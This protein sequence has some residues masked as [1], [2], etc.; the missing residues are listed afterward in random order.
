MRKFLALAG[1]ALLALMPSV[2]QA[3]PPAPT[4]V[5]GS[6]GDFN[7]LWWNATGTHVGHNIYQALRSDGLAPFSA[8]VK[9]AELRDSAGNHTHTY[10]TEAPQAE[11][12][13]YTVTSVD[14]AGA[15]SPQSASFQCNPDVKWAAGAETAGAATLGAGS[16]W[17][18]I[19][20]ASS[21]RRGIDAPVIQKGFKAYRHTLL[22]G[23][24]SFGERCESAQGNA[25]SSD[26][27]PERLYNEGDTLW[28]AFAVYIPDG[29]TF[30]SPSDSGCPTQG[31]GGLITQEKQ[32]GSCGTPAG[33]IVAVRPD[34]TDSSIVLRQRNSAET[35]CGNATMKTLWQLPVQRNKWIKVIRKF[36]FQPTSAGYIETY[37]D[38]DGDA[39][40][41]FTPVAPSNDGLSKPV[42]RV[43]NP[44]GGIDGYR[45]STWTQKSGSSVDHPTACVSDQCSHQRIGI[46]RDPDVDGNSIVYH[47]SVVVGASVGDVVA[48]AF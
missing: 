30:C 44:F 4:G 1:M 27:S 38:T 41:N 47:D 34:G 11:A 6:C 18:T 10:F 14:S 25:S 12:A 39:A 3:A 45:I 29:F 35:D 33:G 20:C 17:S 32:L 40:N 15:E 36:H 48:V 19:S 23:D 22:D 43:T 16:E 46:Y 24:D 37:A 13:R 28:I 26:L 5:A 42:T 8:A 21:T 9:I 2:A 7:L 31:D